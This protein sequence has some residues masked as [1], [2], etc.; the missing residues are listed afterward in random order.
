[1]QRIVVKIPCYSEQEMWVD[2]E[3][4]DK[5]AAE[6]TIDTAQTTTTRNDCK[7]FK[8]EDW[9]NFVEDEDQGC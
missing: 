1:M 6:F 4:T 5:S 3:L 9:E 8:Y 7:N 2:V